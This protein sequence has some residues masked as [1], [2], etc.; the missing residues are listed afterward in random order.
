MFFRF[1]GVVMH[2]KR[3]DD[4]T[5]Q[6][7]LCETRISLCS[8]QTGVASVIDRV[9]ICVELSQCFSSLSLK[10]DC[11]GVTESIV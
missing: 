4:A 2:V 10:V 8:S 11:P 3:A 9:D 5:F 1:F 7:E 6:K